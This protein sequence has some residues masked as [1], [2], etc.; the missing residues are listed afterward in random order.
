MIKKSIFLAA[1]SIFCINSF[2]QDETDVLIFS[3]SSYTESENS[4]FISPLNN[5]DVLNSNNKISNDFSTLQE[6][7]AFTS[8]TTGST[9]S[10]SD[11]NPANVNANFDPAVVIDRDED[12]HLVFIEDT[13]GHIVIA[14]STDKGA[15]WPG[16][17]T[18]ISSEDGDKPHLWVDNKKYINGD[19]SSNSYKGNL[20]AAYRPDSPITKMKFTMRTAGTS[21]WTTPADIHTGLTGATNH[22]G[23]NIQTGTEGEVYACWT[24]HKNNEG[25][26]PVKPFAIAFNRSV[27][28]GATWGDGHSGNAWKTYTYNISGYGMKSAPGLTTPKTM[29]ANTFPSMTVNQQNGYIFIVWT[30]FS[31]NCVNSTF[32]SECLDDPDVYVMR[33]ENNGDDWS[34]PVK[35]NQ[36][37]I[38]DD[39]QWFPWIACD[40]ASGVLVC[41]YYDSRSDNAKANT[42]VSISYD[43]G[44][45]W[46]DTKISDTYWDAIPTYTTFN[47]YAG[48][49]IGVDVYHNKAVPVWSDDRGS[50]N[51]L[52]YANPFDVPCPE[53]MNLTY[54]DYNITDETSTFTYDAAYSVQE[55]LNVAGGSSTYNIYS[56]AKVHMRAGVSVT[57]DVGFKCEA[58]GLL[59]VTTADIGDPDPVCSDLSQRMN[60]ESTEDDTKAYSP[61]T[62]SNSRFPVRT[63]PNPTTNR[64]INTYVPIITPDDTDVNNPVPVVITIFNNIGE[65]VYQER[66][67]DWMNELDLSSQKP[68]LYLINVT[69]GDK[70]YNGKIILQ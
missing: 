40:E 63:F 8:T 1:L 44:D 55:D 53:D 39:D 26:Q 12:Y 69:K 5:T 35:V 31:D 21:T 51:L 32:P 25:S 19:A 36:D 15:T 22:L 10:W 11:R 49:Y 48:D 2:A 4:V 46:T 30:N 20:Y 50:T 67:N 60:N 13:P 62:V 58:G 54:G 41:T 38:T 14:T 57:L 29:N 7:D 28:G 66:A 34:A 45:T 6:V 3:S 70:V 68:G 43:Q 33:S 16:T 23:V 18:D 47:T 37:D 65:I 61:F 56:G 9:G 27:D 42:Y 52:A 17:N 24:M 64:K 59:T